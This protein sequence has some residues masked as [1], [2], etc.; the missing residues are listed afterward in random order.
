MSLSAV[1]VRRCV[2]LILTPT[3]HH[4]T[5]TLLDEFHRLCC[6]CKTCLQQDEHF[7]RCFHG[8][9]YTEPV[10]CDPDKNPLEKLQPKTGDET[11]FN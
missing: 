5:N 6:L 10:F 2:V 8:K 11:V 9:K 4:S 3:S 7:P 1:T